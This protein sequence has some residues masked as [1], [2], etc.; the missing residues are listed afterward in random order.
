MPRIRQGYI[1]VTGADGASIIDYALP[2]A[3]REIATLMTKEFEG[4][5]DRMGSNPNRRYTTEFYKPVKVSDY[6]FVLIREYVWPKDEKPD[7]IEFRAEGRYVEV[8]FDV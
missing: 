2:V 6:H 8:E 3:E 4:L 5:R 1:K 7:S